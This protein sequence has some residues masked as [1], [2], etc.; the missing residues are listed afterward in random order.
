MAAKKNL[1]MD[2]LKEGAIRIYPGMIDVYPQF[3]EEHLLKVSDLEPKFNGCYATNN[4][5]VAFISDNEMYV[6]PVTR[7]IR[8]LLISEGFRNEYFYVPFSN[9]DYPKAEQA[10]WNSLREK[11]GIEHQREFLEDCFSYC[12]KHN[13][14]SIKE[15][16]LKNCFEMP[17][18]GVKI[19]RFGYEDTYYPLINSMCFDCIACQYIGKFCTNNGKVIFAYR[20]GKTYVA[21]GYGILTELRAAGYTESGIFVPFSNGEQIIDSGLRVRWESIIKI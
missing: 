4:S 6:T 17:A 15:E 13:I 20:N 11:A 14:G 1:T 9:G 19:K 18:T 5:T 12:D 7:A 10:K 21:K 8:N 2:S 16:T 3:S